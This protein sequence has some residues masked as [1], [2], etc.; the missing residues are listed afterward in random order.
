MISKSE[1]ERL[2]SICGSIFFSGASL[3]GTYND[4][5]FSKLLIE[6]YTGLSSTMLNPYLRECVPK[7][8]RPCYDL[9]ECLLNKALDEIVV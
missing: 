7:T 3:K 5:N 9:F 8:Q 2:S 1:I 4:N 6:Y